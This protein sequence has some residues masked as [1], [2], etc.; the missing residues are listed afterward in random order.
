MTGMAYNT[1]TNN[2]WVPP[3]TKKVF[4]GMWRREGSDFLLFIYFFEEV[5]FLKQN[6]NSQKV[7]GMI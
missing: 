2:Q 7:K 5:F 4:N 1:L 6:S 3:D